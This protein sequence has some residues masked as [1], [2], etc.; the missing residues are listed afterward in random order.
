[1]SRSTRCLLACILALA[2]CGETF[3]NGFFD[4]DLPFIAAAPSVDALRLAGPTGEEDPLGSREQAL[5]EELAEFYVFTRQA[6]VSTNRAVIGLLRDVDRLV[7]APPSERTADS[8]VWGPFSDSLD[9]FESRFEMTR[10]E[11]SFDY[12]LSRR[13]ALEV[14]APFDAALLEGSFD[15]TARTGQLTLDLDA[16]RRLTG[17]Q[18]TG[19]VEVVYR[20][21]GGVDLQLR[22]TRFSEGDGA[23]IDLDY[24]YRQIDGEG[25][26][27]YAFFEDTNRVEVRSRWLADGSGRADARI[28]PEDRG[29]FVLTE[30]W[31]SRFHQVYFSDAT[32]ER[33]DASKCAFAERALPE[34][35]ISP[36][37]SEGD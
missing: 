18:G 14:D 22:F 11:G 34:R 29:A 9:A 30:C 8:R 36:T 31:D 2:G 7:E 3:S 24:A 35:I 15:P 28:T 6:T 26:F 20:F 21:E 32:T 23:P 33:G 19:T 27:E 16:S 13:S 12:A 25:D 10:T 1:M 4:D 37:R 5:G 17:S